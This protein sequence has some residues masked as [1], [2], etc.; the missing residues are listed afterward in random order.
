MSHKIVWT[1][2]PLGGS[3]AIQ[4]DCERAC[5]DREKCRG[6]RRGRLAIEGD[7][8]RELRPFTIIGDDEGIMPHIA[9]RDRARA[10]FGSSTKAVEMMTWEGFNTGSDEQKAHGIK[11]GFR[12]RADR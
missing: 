2:K 3:Q 10:G 5:P 7:F 8:G 1:S 4:I 6:E 11:R 12:P 9:S